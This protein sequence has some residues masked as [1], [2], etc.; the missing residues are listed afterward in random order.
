MWELW[1][2]RRETCLPPL[3]TASIR[4]NEALIGGN[5]KVYDVEL[6]SDVKGITFDIN[7]NEYVADRAIIIVKPDGGV[8]TDYPYNSMLKNMK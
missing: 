5:K 3:L 6:P 2:N 4:P 7:G 8:K 1:L